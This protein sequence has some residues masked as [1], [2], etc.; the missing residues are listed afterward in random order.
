M[1]AL[2]EKYTEILNFCSWD[3][4]EQGEVYSEMIPGQ[5]KMILVGEKQLVLPTAENLRRYDPKKMIYFHPFQEQI[6]RGESEV[7]TRLRTA[8][9]VRI[10]YITFG[11]SQALFSILTHKSDH[12]QFNPE[13]RDLLTS[14]MEIDDKTL[15]NYT[16]FVLSTFKESVASYFVS[17]YLKK[18]G[19]YRG[20][21]HARVGVVNFTFDEKLEKFSNKLARKG[22]VPVF[23]SMLE[24]VYPESSTDKE[25]WNDYSD[26]L[27]IPWLHCL[28]KTAFL[29]FDRTNTLIERYK[30]FSPVLEDFEVNPSLFTQQW[31]DDFE[32]L[33]ALR[34]EIRK[35]PVLKGNEG[36]VVEKDSATR[37]LAEQI[38]E[39]PPPRETVRPVLEAPDTPPP[40][41]QPQSVP[42]Q[43]HPEPQ[44]AVTT[45]EGKLDFFEAAKGNPE[46]VRA[47]Y[48]EQRRMYDVPWDVRGPDPRSP[49]YNQN[50]DPRYQAPYDP[51]QDP[52][53][54]PRY[55]QRYDPRYDN[56]QVNRPPAPHGYRR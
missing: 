22:D 32:D 52:R 33:S 40:R 15:E 17:I 10:N 29:F 34:G 3:V 18:G 21:K 6:N 43:P 41:T 50:Y 7:I 31:I 36:S 35:L 27:S 19:L 42:H 25:A 5:R 1:S 2:L 12:S 28:L 30:A 26:D 48:D 56:R 49:G 20:E 47:Y 55:D 39:A 37:A 24:F 13:Q 14:V 38:Q 11:V 9:S 45:P 54:D 51:R 44:R 16:Q 8:L 46:V 23:K 4:N 53:Y